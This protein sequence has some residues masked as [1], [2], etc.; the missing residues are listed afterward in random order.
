MDWWKWDLK[1]SDEHV[2]EFQWHHAHRITKEVT[3]KMQ[4]GSSH[5]VST[6]VQQLTR[7][8]YRMPLLELEEFH[9]QMKELLDAGYIQLS[10]AP[11]GALV[12]FRKK[13]IS[14]YGCALATE[15]LAS[16][17]WKTSIQLEAF[18]G[19]WALSQEGEV[20][21]RL[22]KGIRETKKTSNS[23]VNLGIAR[24]LQGIWGANRCF[25]LHY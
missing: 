16:L 14:H 12:L 18:E 8:L 5:W 20:F 22:E 15:H 21:N 13:H 3:T 17:S 6:R 25:G 10:K 4:S 19:E 9:R 2:G 24:L 11:H 1:A 7:T 23:K